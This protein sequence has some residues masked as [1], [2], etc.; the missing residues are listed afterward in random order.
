[1]S[2]SNAGFLNFD[3]IANRVQGLITHKEHPGFC[4][5]KKKDAGA[6][7]AAEDGP[8]PFESNRG[9]N[10][11]HSVQHEADP[12]Q[13]GRFQPPGVPTEDKLR[14]DRVPIGGMGGRDNNYTRHEPS[15][16]FQYPGLNYDSRQER[17][18][19]HP[20]ENFRPQPRE[21]PMD[22]RMG[23][24]RFPVGV[25]RGQPSRYPED[26]PY[27]EPPYRGRAPTDNRSFPQRRATV[28]QG[29]WTESDV[30]AMRN[31]MAGY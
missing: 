18:N 31:R 5:R 23:Y 24:E 20:R 26:E 19:Y 21:A 25:N 3:Q 13:G 14:D 22:E 6:G 27:L 12:T 11:G 2:L 8:R 4:F 16:E 17:A 29:D 1:M 9:P 10:G 7:Q 15:N 30:R 28:G